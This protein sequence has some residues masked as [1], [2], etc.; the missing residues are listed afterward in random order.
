MKKTARIFLFLPLLFLAACSSKPVVKPP[1]DLIGKD[2][3]VQIVADQLIVES[4]VFNAPPQYNKDT[5]TRA[6]YAQL[7]E[8]YNITI[9]RYQS[10]L[11]YYFS[12]K[13]RMED[14]MN[15]AKSQIDAKKSQLP[16]Q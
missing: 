6:L 8:K 7:L 12:D 2:T 15:R 9:P 3:I 13:K 4:L 1:A 10:S 16:T 14:I 11:T 5:L